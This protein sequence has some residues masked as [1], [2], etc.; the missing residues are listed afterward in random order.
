M[1]NFYNGQPHNASFALRAE[2]CLEDLQLSSLSILQK[3]QGF[4]Y[5]FDA[6]ALSD[7]ASVRP[8]DSIADLGTGTGIIPLLLYGREQRVTIDCVEIQE[9]MADMATRTMHGNALQEKIT[10]HHADLRKI[11]EILPHA[12]YTLV[13]C[14]P[15][16]EKVD[17]G[18]L[19]PDVTRRVAMSEVLCT[20]EDVMEASRHLLT[21]GGRL[22]LCLPAKR[23]LECMDAMR[24]YAIEP[25][26]VRFVH[27]NQNRPARLML[28]EG[29]RGGK[30]NLEVMPPLLA[31]TLDNQDTDEI[32]RM[33][34][35]E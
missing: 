33:Y 8:N 7:F 18:L 19:A 1:P 24:K 31:K 26:R 21:Y 5:G 15:P 25:K 13:T 28:L 6:V 20:L 17:H 32:K 27:A 30:A 2:E 22:C 9:E 23:A 16:Y 10:V 12:R 29:I 14:N 3:K 34:H 35:M 11:K 4:R